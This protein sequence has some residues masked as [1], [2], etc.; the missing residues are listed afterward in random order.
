MSSTHAQSFVLPLL[1]FTP[2]PVEPKVSLLSECAAFA[3]HRHMPIL[4]TIHA[5]A[6]KLIT[7]NPNPKR[8]TTND[9]FVSMPALTL[10]LL[11]KSSCKLA[12]SISANRISVGTVIMATKISTYG[13]R[14]LFYIN[15]TKRCTQ[16]AINLNLKEKSN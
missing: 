10:A 3:F 9:D 14:T 11:P 1:P 5:H 7:R 6:N 12:S 4:C 13:F 2:E 15:E 8:R 16:K